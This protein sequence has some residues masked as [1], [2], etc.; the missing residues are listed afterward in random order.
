MRQESRQRAH[1]G[2]VM[3]ARKWL[4]RASALALTL[5]AGIARADKVIPIWERDSHDQYK[6]MNNSLA[7][8]V[9]VIDQYGD[10]LTF[11]PGVSGG[12]WWG[13]LDKC[14]DSLE[15]ADDH[16]QQVVLWA[17]CGDDIKAVDERK[18]KAD[19]D[20][21]N[22]PAWKKLGAA[23]EAE[24]KEDP[25]VALILNQVEA[26][27]ADWKTFEAK[28]H[29]AIVLY[30][31]LKDG[32][33]SSKSNAPQFDGCWEA[34][35]PVFAKAVR[36]TKFSWDNEGDDAVA[37]RVAEIIGTNPATY[38]TVA[39]FGMCAYAA[40]VTGGILAQVALSA[41]GAV[42]G[43]RTMLISKLLDPKFKPKF[44]DRSYKWETG[45]RGSVATVRG[46]DDGAEINRPWP[47]GP[48]R[49]QVGVIKKMT[50]DGDDTLVTF[51]GAIVEDCLDW[52]ETG[53]IRTW[54][55]AGDPVYERKCLRRGKTEDDAPDDATMG[56]KLLD[57][58]KVGLGVAFDGW[59]PEEVYNDKTKKFVAILSVSVKGSPAETPRKE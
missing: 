2:G 19:E 35:Q 15:R 43:W 44:T 30:Q 50:K 23:I 42:F 47:G 6:A 49:I 37:G 59:F 48:M 40:H 22:I 33:R 25:G 46:G 13:Y 52:K 3:D 54:D 26:A 51:S 18:L 4:I 1:I 53:K 31:K 12:A 56:T 8:A 16:V 10:K 20:K 21:T 27:K 5:T 45:E 58:F 32:V 11:D 55:T 34:T 24:A 7:Y 36:A 57:G 41:K 28:N 9:V 39:N 29:A 14:G 17:V 38:Y